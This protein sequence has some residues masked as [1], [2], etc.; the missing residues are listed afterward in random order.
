ME[1]ALSH[2]FHMYTNLPLNMT[3]HIPACFGGD[4]GVA[5]QHWG[6][7]GRG[8]RGYTWAGEPKNLCDYDV[9]LQVTVLNITIYPHMESV[10]D[11]G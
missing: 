11:S 7:P 3:D 8:Q 10:H 1:W 5:L 4:K 9:V 6:G 2:C